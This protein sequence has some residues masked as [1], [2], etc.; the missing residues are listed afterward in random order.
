VTPHTIPPLVGTHD[1]VAAGGAGTGRRFG[2]TFTLLLPTG[3]VA[4]DILLDDASARVA[5]AFTPLTYDARTATAPLTATYTTTSDGTVIVQLDGPRRLVSVRLSSA[6]P[7]TSALLV[8]RVDGR[9]SAEDPTLEL[10][11]VSGVDGQLFTAPDPFVADRFALR[12]RTVTGTEVVSQSQIGAVTAEGEPHNATL[13][14]RHTGTAANTPLFTAAIAGGPGFDIRVPGEELGR[15]LAD[16]LRPL[17]DPVALELAVGADGP[18]R[19]RFDVAALPYAVASTGF[20]DLPLQM[21]DLADADELLGRLRGTIEPVSAHLRA[22][23]SP[24]ARA[25][26]DAGDPAAAALA[27]SE[28]S[29]VLATT[30]LW[31]PQRFAGVPLSAEVLALVAE[32]P[33]GARRD[34]LNRLLIEAAWPGAFTPR[35]RER[36][37]DV[38]ANASGPAVAVSVP[39]GAT[40]AAGTLVVRPLVDDLRAIQAPS[41]ALDGSTVALALAAPQATAAAAQ[42]TTAVRAEGVEVALL[43]RD[44]AAAFRAELRADHQDGPGGAILRTAALRVTVRGGVVWVRAQFDEAVTLQPGR[45]WVVVRT[46]AGRAVWLT[47]TPDPDHPVTVRTKQDG[48]VWEPLDTQG[49]QPLLRLVTA[50]SAAPS[51][52]TV[53]ASDATVQ[54]APGDDGTLAF[55]LDPLL[56]PGTALALRT[57]SMADGAIVVAAPTVTYDLA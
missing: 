5:G 7:A 20:A 38:V 26:V 9:V 49:L 34:R 50:A 1:V 31:D 14:L 40:T 47:A 12:R 33:S 32:A 56:V 24:R 16:T 37:L 27:V 8:H 53:V 28:L 54:P 52:I 15:L 4:D 13:V 17:P 42:M 21:S 44:D 55:V 39:A 10:S 51:A 2:A 46:D 29:G 11:G 22:A 23:L 25:S 30:A 19:V 35:D 43:V 48:G 41:G 57:P 36:R 3:G 18:S 6:T 45:V